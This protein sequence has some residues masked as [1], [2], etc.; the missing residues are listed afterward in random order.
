LLVLEK[1]RFS[2]LHIFYQ[3]IDKM[4]K[5]QNFIYVLGVAALLTS[6]NQFKGF[7]DSGKLEENEKAIQNYII[8]SQQ[9]FTRD[10][11]GLF[12]SI[13]QSRPDSARAK[14][15]EQVS[16]Y[17]SIYTLAGTFVDSTEK[18]KGK[19]RRIP[20]G[21]G[22][23]EIPGIERAFTLL[24]K[25]EKATLLLPYFLAYGS[26]SNSK[27]PAYAPMRVEIEIADIRTEDKQIE[28]YIKSKNYTVAEKTVDGLRIVLL[29]SV[30][31]GAPIGIN[32]KVDI[33]YTGRAL[34]DSI[35]DKNNWNNFTTGSGTSIAG[36]DEGIRKLV[37]GQKAVLIF[38]SSM[39]YKEN[40]VVDQNL[41]R[42][43][44]LPYAPLAFEVKATLKN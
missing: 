28:D 12:Y 11:T 33:A 22:F 13:S 41:G 32:K 10:T 40:G 16:Y 17:L 21:T 19:P 8:A 6:C 26:S 4:S 3:S 36:F 25:G 14:V 42:W 29:D 43:V 44:I 18:S 27:I 2:Q 30:L 7:D 38:P 39:G 35:F 20:Y 9:T 15:G 24:K 23:L 37:S 31:P 5:L 1:Q 34:N